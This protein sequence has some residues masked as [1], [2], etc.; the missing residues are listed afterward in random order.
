M[1]EDGARRGHTA[2]LLKGLDSLCSAQQSP[3]S[4]TSQI[5]IGSQEQSHLRQATNVDALVGKSLKP[6]SGRPNKSRHVAHPVKAALS[7]LVA[8]VLGAPTNTV[9]TSSSGLSVG[10]FAD[11]CDCA[12]TA[13]NSATGPGGEAHEVN[14]SSATN[15]DGLMTM[16]N[17]NDGDFQV[18]WFGEVNVPGT[19][20]IGAGATVRITG[21]GL[22]T[23][24]NSSLNGG[25]ALEH[26]TSRVT[27]PSGLKSAAVGVGEP[28]NAEGIDKIDS[29]GPI[30]FVNNG[31]LIVKDLIV[32]GGF[33]SDIETSR[34]GG[35]IY[36][37]NSN[38]TIA[39][40]DFS[41]NFAENMGG[42]IFA[43]D[44]TLHVSDTMFRYCRAGQV[45]TFENETDEGAGG[46]IYVS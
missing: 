27:L 42:G 38:V 41:D 31:N 33:A 44:S 43:V 21:D 25:E 12:T 16:F 20:C 28:N 9:L 29:F 2:P 24:G 45:S 34:S 30:F 13:T 32:R 8:A 17:C 22:S 4:T 40:C 37:V 11:P 26:L 46:G 23:P 19:I 3:P 14:V 5:S 39:G 6:A 35:G 18:N 36:S 15:N 10:V 1:V 7:L